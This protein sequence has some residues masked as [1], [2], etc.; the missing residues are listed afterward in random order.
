MCDDTRATQSKASEERI[1]NAFTGQTL[2]GMLGGGTAQNKQS[3]PDYRRQQAEARSLGSDLRAA[4][5]TNSL[6]TA[7]IPELMQ[8]ASELS[9][10]TPAQPLSSASE[11]GCSLARERLDTMGHLRQLA[12]VLQYCGIAI[13]RRG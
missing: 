6:L 9:G 8:T 5:L 10:S 2:G 4:R 11:L 12:D 3:E 1:G 13:H 7:L